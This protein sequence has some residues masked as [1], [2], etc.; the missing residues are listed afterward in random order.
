MIDENGQKYSGYKYP[1]NNIEYTTKQNKLFENIEF[2]SKI[3][4]K[5]STE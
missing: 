1:K 4:S 2:S 3:N 5:E